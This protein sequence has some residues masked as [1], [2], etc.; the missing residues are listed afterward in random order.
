MK[1]IKN[2]FSLK[3]ARKKIHIRELSI[4]K[5]DRRRLAPKSILTF[6]QLLRP[7]LVCK[8]DLSKKNV[9]SIGIKLPLN[10][11]KLDEA[12]TLFL[13]RDRTIGG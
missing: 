7:L 10:A 2:V 11:Q 3:S 6:W 8:R 13:L 1:E 5:I 12:E 4:I 9:K